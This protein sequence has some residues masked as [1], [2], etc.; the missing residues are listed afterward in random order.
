MPQASVENK[1]GNNR[2]QCTVWFI[3]S[4]HWLLFRRWLKTAWW[5]QRIFHIWTINL[6][7][8]QSACAIYKTNQQAP[9]NRAL[10]HK[11]VFFPIL[12]Y[13]KEQTS[14]IS[15]TMPGDFITPKKQEVELRT[16]IAINNT[17]N[18]WALSVLLLARWREQ[19]VVRSDY[20]F[21]FSLKLW[22]LSGKYLQVSPDFI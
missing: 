19:E 13:K 10:N 18:C 9:F 15:I 20:I 1:L 17:S 21:P 6:V 14:L 16:L 12:G 2:L 8:D 11:T 22:A 7:V 5:R 4:S 3:K